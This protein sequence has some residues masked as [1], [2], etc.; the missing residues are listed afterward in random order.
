M[1]EKMLKIKLLDTEN[2]AKKKFHNVTG[3]IVSKRHFPDAQS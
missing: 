3:S 1:W 2:T